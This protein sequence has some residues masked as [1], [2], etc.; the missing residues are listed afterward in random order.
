MAIQLDAYDEAY[1]PSLGAGGD[2]SLHHDTVQIVAS[3][4]AV[5]VAPVTSLAAAIGATPVGSGTACAGQ[6]CMWLPHNAGAVTLT[7]TVAGAPANGVASVEFRNGPGPGTTVLCPPRSFAAPPPRATT[8]AQAVDPSGVAK[9]TLPVAELGRGD[10]TLYACP[11]D[12]T[13]QQYGACLQMP[14]LSVCGAG[15]ASLCAANLTVGR[16]AACPPWATCALPAS[17]VVGRNVDDPTH[18]TIYYLAFTD[19]GTNLVPALFAQ[20]ADAPSA[21][22]AQRPGTQLG[23]NHYFADTLIAT[24]EGSGVYAVRC[25][26]CTGAPAGNTSIARVDCPN[27][28]DAA[29]SR[30]DFVTAP[31]GGSFRQL[32]VA[33]PAAMLVSNATPPAVI[34]GNAFL[35]PAV[36]SQATAPALSIGTLQP[37]STINGA[38]NSTGQHWGTTTAG[39]IVAW[40]TSGGAT[41]PVLF[42]PSLPGNHS[43]TLQAAAGALGALDLAVFPGGEILYSYVSGTD[44]YLGAA[45]HDGTATT[46]KQLAPFRIGPSGSTTLGR[47]F[48]VAAPGVLVGTIP[49]DTNASAFQALE[50]NLFAGAATTPAAF[51][52][53]PHDGVA[54]GTLHDL[55]VL[56][57]TGT[58]ATFGVSDDRAKAIFV[59]DDPPPAGV[60]GP[61]WR[62]HLVDLATGTATT[63]AA[64][65]RL[66]CAATGNPA[67]AP[68]TPSLSGAAHYPRFVHGAAAYS[69]GAPTGTHRAVVWEEE[70]PWSGN[71][72]LRHARL[73]FA[74]WTGGATP[75]VATVDR[76]TTYQTT[77]VGLT[78]IPTAMESAAGGALYFLSDSDLG[79]ADLYAVP[80][81]ASG[82][83]V[84]ASARVLGGVFGFKVREDKAALLVAASDGTLYHARLAG[85]G[86]LPFL[87]AIA[88]GGPAGDP[89]YDGMGALSFGFTPDGDRAYVVVGQ[90][91]YH[92]TSFFVLG[93]LG[94]LVSVDLRPDR[95]YAQ[96]NWGRIAFQGGNITAAFLSSAAEI[97]D[98]LSVDNLGR[99]RLTLARA[100]AATSHGDTGLFTG[101]PSGAGFTSF[102]FSPSLDGSEG[103][104]LYASQANAFRSD[105]TFLP[106]GGGSEGLLQAAT[107][108]PF[109][110]PFRPE[111]SQLNGILFSGASSSIFKVWGTV[112]PATSPAPFVTICRGGMATPTAQTRQ[113]PDA[114]E[115]LYSFT[116]S[117]E[118][119]TGAYTMW[120]PLSGRAAP[121]PI[122]P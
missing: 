25:S 24:P 13:G 4:T 47:D 5:P 70:L 104:V 9:L 63:L 102:R 101:D 38:A 105:G 121:A 84:A 110:G 41:A 106:I 64:S 40:A 21:N 89:Q 78:P 67:P 44:R 52:P 73:S 86:A 75:A 119:A 59:T 14:F 49:A 74:T 50:I 33:T 8:C 114:K 30:Q 115:L 112:A 93:F 107:A 3:I 109:G 34:G 42:H 83:G 82:S 6:P 35:A 7:A 18:H 28:G 45:Y 19:P 10:V 103:M 92:A 98:D 62:L 60:A 46:P 81:S 36:S 100:S 96:T 85:G 12:A 23:A 53:A 16:V 99:G 1:L 80:L 118:A 77:S 65:E 2:N 37:V 90:Q 94:E 51:K 76:L 117:G 88:D 69:G 26:T 11:V 31:G 122:A 113:T 55:G 71:T 111:W 120:L 79:G 27:V 17:P 72:S 54:T 108:S 58:A 20:D 57:R 48:V 22:A 29:C 95:A 91:A 66:L 39:A 43:L 32:H 68:C 15:G 97:V 56:A 116:G 61:V 87:Y